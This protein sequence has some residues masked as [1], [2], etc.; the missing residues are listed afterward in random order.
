L[1]LWTSVLTGIAV[2]VGGVVS[3]VG[4]VVPHAVRGLVGPGHRLLMPASIAA[5]GSFV[6]LADVAARR[7]IA[8]E[9]LQLGI[10]TAA[11][12]APLFLVL[13]VRIRAEKIA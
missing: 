3:F 11:I 2:A 6:T 5:G 7:V 8:P 9:E 12:G 1:L 4:L 13:L 10:V